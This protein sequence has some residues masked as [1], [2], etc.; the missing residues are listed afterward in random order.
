MPPLPRKEAG[1]EAV[2]SHAPRRPAGVCIESFSLIPFFPLTSSI[3][4]STGYGSAAFEAQAVCPHWMMCWPQSPLPKAGH[5]RSIRACSF[6][7]TNAQG[8][9]PGPRTTTHQ[10]IPPGHSWSLGGDF[11]S[12]PPSRCPPE[13][14]QCPLLLSSQ[15]VPLSADSPT[16]LTSG[17]PAPFL[18]S[19]LSP[20][21]PGSVVGF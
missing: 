3:S 1:S 13:P 6:L 14:E 16:C 15:G 4:L 9:S 21:P 7:P 11:S 12:A 2:G 8:C 18:G 17:I 20:T 10:Q 5:L 19:R